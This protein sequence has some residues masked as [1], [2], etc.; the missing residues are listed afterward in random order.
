MVTVYNSYICIHI[1][2]IHFYQCI[3]Y[4]LINFFKLL[5]LR[6]NYYIPFTYFSKLLKPRF[7]LQ[8]ILLTVEANFFINRNYC[9]G[10]Y[11]F[12]YLFIIVFLFLFLISFLWRGSAPCT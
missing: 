9:C 5:K 1:S 7:L 3:I 2:S 10:V 4:C 11:L 8:Y 12:I 6:F